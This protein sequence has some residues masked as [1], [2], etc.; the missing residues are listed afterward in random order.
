MMEIKSEGKFNGI[1]YNHIKYIRF[2]FWD[3]ELKQEFSDWWIREP[4]DVLTRVRDREIE[5]LLNVEYHKLRN[6]S[7]LIHLSEPAH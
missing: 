1:I 5:K 6:H 3:E 2:S 7:N 4:L